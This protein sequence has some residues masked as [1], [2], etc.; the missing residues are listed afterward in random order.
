MFNKPNQLIFYINVLIIAF[1]AL[2][3]LFTPFFVVGLIFAICAALLILDQFRQNKSAFTISD[4]RK[5]L[6]IH[7]DGGNK[8]TMTQTQMTTACHVDN[9]E[10]WF[11]NIRAIG[12]ISNFKINNEQPDDQRKENG[13]YHVCMRIPPELKLID[14]SDLMLT[15]EYQDAFTQNQGTLSH[16]IDDDTQH[17]HMT[18]QLP[19]GRAISTARFF[20]KHDGKE[21]ALLPPVVTGSTKIETTVKNPKLGVEYCL[22]WNWSEPGLLKKLS[23]LFK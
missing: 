11:K 21:E 2:V 22:Q 16:V 9:S 3:A 7:D 4:L 15:Y 10:Y 1:G 20:C 8:A 19:E 23:S 12:S 14:G 18:V 13:N 17:L 6:T 5:I